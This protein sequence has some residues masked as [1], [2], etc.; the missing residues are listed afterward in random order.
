M[1]WT[2]QIAQKS[3]AALG[4]GIIFFIMLITSIVDKSHFSALQKAFTS[5]YEDRLMVENY[6]YKLSD[7]FNQK[8][9]LI[10]KDSK[11]VS[12]FDD[13]IQQL[14]VQYEQT[15]LTPDEAIYFGRLKT[16][17]QQLKS[18]EHR[19][20]SAPEQGL[21]SSIEQEHIS[22][23]SNLKLLSDIQ[24]TETRR[25]LK[26]SDQLIASSN[27]N[28]YLEICSLIV[29]GLLIQALIYSSKSIKPKFR[30]K[31]HLN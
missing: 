21:I 10:E 19:Y 28:S 3:K 27:F 14:I 24:L 9:I 6:I 30:Q 20:I 7:I 25:I 13:D 2:Y 8:K 5:V 22:I 31:S 29:I 26:T 15:R 17:I 16:D 12:Q 1:K 23:S 18:L 11:A 4:L